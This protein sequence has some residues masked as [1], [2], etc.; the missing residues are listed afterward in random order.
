M[1]LVTGKRLNIDWFL[2]LT[3]VLAAPILL[4][5]ISYAFRVYVQIA[6]RRFTGSQSA[7]LHQTGH[8]AG[9]DA[10]FFGCFSYFHLVFKIPPL[11]LLSYYTTETGF[12]IID[13]PVDE[14]DREKL[15]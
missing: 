5:V 11:S 13:S 1:I 2:I 12:T 6:L 7:Q 10:Q 9:A 14:A 4:F 3:D 15:P 8:N